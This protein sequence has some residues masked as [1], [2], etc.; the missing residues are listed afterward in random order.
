MI[1]MS[2]PSAAGALAISKVP[3]RLILLEPGGPPPYDQPELLQIGPP[4]LFAVEPLAV[5]DQRY[6]YLIQLETEPAT[7]RFVFMLVCD[8]QEDPGA[9]ARVPP[10]GAWQRAVNKGTVYLLASNLRLNRKQIA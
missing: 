2:V 3:I 1:N 10:R 5:P 6:L 8:K 9:G 7:R 4:T